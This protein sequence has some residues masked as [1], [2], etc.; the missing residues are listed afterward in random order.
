MPE[1]HTESLRAVRR[2]PWLVGLPKA[3]KRGG[4]QKRRRAKAEAGKSRGRAKPD[5]QKPRGQN[6]GGP[7]R[8]RA[9]EEV[10]TRE[11]GPK[12]RRTSSEPRAL[13]LTF[14]PDEVEVEMAIKPTTRIERKDEIPNA[15]KSCF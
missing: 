2:A 7:K 12:R 5:R 9:K 15:V 11:G 8:R 6:Q 1:A 3:G 14:S 4:G 13:D 10:G